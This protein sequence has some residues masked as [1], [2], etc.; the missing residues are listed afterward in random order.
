MGVAGEI[1]EHG[2][3]PGGGRLGIDDPIGIVP[4]REVA[5]EGVALGQVRE[6]GEE[7]EAAGMVRGMELLQE[8]TAEQP[9]EHQHMQKE[10][11]PA[12]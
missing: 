2:L 10:L 4:W 3:G 11:R 8:A 9:R 6:I 12:R 5:G 1:G 7:A